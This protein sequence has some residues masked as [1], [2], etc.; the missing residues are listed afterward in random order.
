MPTLIA[1]AI[2]LGCACTSFAADVSPQDRNAAIELFQE[3]R[4]AYQAGRFEEA[5]NLLRRAYALDP[6]PTLLYN[7][8][9]A[10]ESGGDIDGAADAYRRY[11]DADPTAK[12]R[13]AIERRIANLE[14]QI[15]ERDEL[16][17]RLEAERQRRA[18]PT[19]PPDAGQVTTVAPPPPS[20]P[21]AVPWVVA[22]TGGASLVVGAVLG[23]LAQTEHGKAKDAI[24]M[25]DA[26]DADDRARGLARGAN[27]AFGVGGALTAA[28]LVWGLIDVVSA[29]GDAVEERDVEEDEFSFTPVLGPRGVSVVGRF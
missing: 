27:I 2:A 17:N 26:V 18:Q 9:R 21:S 25:Q 24:T 23:G 4:K 15:R 19:P 20:K 13:A 14:A 5:A 8:A 11:I 22:G 10:L 6:A 7:L 29:R 12:D 1:G 16:R 28:G 3:S